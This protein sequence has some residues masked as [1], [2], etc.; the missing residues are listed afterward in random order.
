MGGMGPGFVSQ[1]GFLLH[2]SQV[3]LLVQ[4]TAGV[5]PVLAGG[6]WAQACGMGR[7]VGTRLLSFQ[8]QG[9]FLRRGTS[10]PCI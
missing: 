10:Q 1:C 8:G 7:S 6:S 9:L 5:W 3:S 2:I 4:L